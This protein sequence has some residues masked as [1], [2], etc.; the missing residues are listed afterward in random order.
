MDRHPASAMRSSRSQKT[1]SV[2][3]DPTG[4]KRPPT[5]SRSR[6]LPL[7]PMSQSRPPWAREKGWVLA[8]LFCPQVAVRM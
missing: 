8:A 7:C 6:K 3:V 1:S 4:S 2:S 5:S